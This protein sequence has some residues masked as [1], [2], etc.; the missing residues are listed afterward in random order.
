[1][2]SFIKIV[3]ENANQN[4]VLFWLMMI[5]TILNGIT[6]TLTPLAASQIAGLLTSTTKT[7]DTFLGITMH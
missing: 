3:L 7:T 2:G 5:I 6:A 4:P 1:M